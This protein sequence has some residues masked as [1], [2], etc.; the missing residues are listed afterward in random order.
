[1]YIQIII[2]QNM[3]ILRAYVNGFYWLKNNYYDTSNRNLGYYSE[4]QTDLSNY[5]KSMVID[6]LID[7][8]NVDTIRDKLINYTTIKV[9]SKNV[10]EQL[11]HKLVT[12]SQ[13]HTNCI[14]ELFILNQS[15]HVPIIVYNE[16]NDVIYIFDDEIIDNKDNMNQVKIDEM[17]NKNNKFNAINLRFIFFTNKTIPDDIEV[18]YFKNYSKK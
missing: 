6:W 14:I 18:L 16:N 7:L 3:T 8:R 1:M 11:I 15:Q 5:F 10:A 4:L 2:P 9:K 17:L 13:V 12:N